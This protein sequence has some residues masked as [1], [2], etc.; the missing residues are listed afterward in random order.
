MK[1]SSLRDEIDRRRKV[2]KAAKRRAQQQKE[3]VQ[4]ARTRQFGKCYFDCYGLQAPADWEK[5]INLIG[6]NCRTLRINEGNTIT[7][8]R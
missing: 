7:F 5:V 1:E 2:K 4:R 8:D 3:D 6:V